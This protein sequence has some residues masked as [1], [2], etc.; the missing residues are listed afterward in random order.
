MAEN[1]MARDSAKRV[2]IYSCSEV[3]FVLKRNLY[4]L[5]PVLK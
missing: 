2:R 3:S 1:L 4:Q 5:Q